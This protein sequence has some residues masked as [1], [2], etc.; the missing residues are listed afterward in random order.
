MFVLCVIVD[1]S[2]LLRTTLGMIRSADNDELVIDYM[3]P[4][5]SDTPGMWPG[6]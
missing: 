3:H 1:R 4:F 2:E 5:S 6:S